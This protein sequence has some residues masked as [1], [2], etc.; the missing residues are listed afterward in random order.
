MPV[1]Y[2]ELA[3]ELDVQ[4]GER[5]GVERRP[6]RST[7]NKS[8]KGMVLDPGDPDSR[9]AGSFFTNPVLSAAQYA[10]VAAGR[11][12]GRFPGSTR[13]TGRVKVPA[14]W[15]IEHAGFG[16]GYGAPGRA[17]S[18][19]STPS[20]SSTRAGRRPPGCWRWRARSGTGCTRAFG[21]T[22]EPEPTR[23]SAS[24]CSVAA[25]RDPLARRRW[26]RAGG[27]G[28]P[29]GRPSRER[30]CGPSSASSGGLKSCTSR[31]ISYWLHQP[32]A[33]EQRV[34][35]PERHRHAG[36]EQG[37]HRHRQRVGRDAQR[38]VR[39]RA[40]LKGDRR[41]GQPLDD[42]RILDRPDAVADPVGVQP[43]QGRR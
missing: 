28:R 25:P 30:T 27:C 41:G 38:Y 17:R 22:L 35:R 18:R 33:E 21:V 19:P 13:A 40:D 5:A 20:R 23:W 29:W 14:A 26:R 42:L 12:Q 10:R 36:L 11:G 4:M 8:R 1:K 6:F 16:K 9:S 15:L 43:V 31:A 39:G 32:R 37:A 2:A 7:E 24:P 34:V 3:S